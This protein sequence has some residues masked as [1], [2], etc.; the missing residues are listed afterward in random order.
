MNDNINQKLNLIDQAA[1][2]ERQTS[3]ESIQ[4]TKAQRYP[5][6]S[7]SVYKITSNATGDGL[8]NCRKLIIDSTDWADATGAS[9]F[10]QVDTANHVVFNIAEDGI[11][12]HVLA[13]G[14][15][16]FSFS[17]TDDELNN[18]IIGFSPKYSWWHA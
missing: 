17:V 18:R 9:K 13:V 16:L 8:Y 3:P 11:A 10:K 1:S 15:Y 7:K 2:S 5:P 4:G 12:G 6:D 14:D